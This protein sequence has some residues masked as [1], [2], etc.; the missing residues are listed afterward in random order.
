[1]IYS[2]KSFS[3]SLF[4]LTLPLSLSP[5]ICVYTYISLSRT[6]Y[7]FVLYKILYGKAPSYLCEIIHPYVP[8]RTL[9]SQQQSLLQVPRTHTQFYSERS[10]SYYGPT[11]WNNLPLNI[12][13]APTVDS[14]KLLLKTFMFTQ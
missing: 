13:N 7:I 12:R 1:M 5:L 14:F 3:L 8:A 4:Q 11:L 10:L 9:R 2:H 6:K